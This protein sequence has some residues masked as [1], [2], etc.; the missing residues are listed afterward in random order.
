MN[1]PKLKNLSFSLLLQVVIQHK[2]LMI[3]VKNWKLLRYKKYLWDKVKKRMPE[4]VLK[5]PSLKVLGFYCK[6]V[7]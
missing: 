2:Q 3:S 7:I 6:I 5:K 1:N 4:L